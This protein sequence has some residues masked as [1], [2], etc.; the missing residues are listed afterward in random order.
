[1][2]A[3]M[4]IALICSALPAFAA[5]YYVDSSEG[6][7]RSAG[8]SPDTAWRGLDKVNATTFQPGDRILLKAGLVWSGRLWPK[9]SGE[10]GRPIAIDQYGEGPKPV[11]NGEG[12]AFE[13]IHLR[14]QQ[15]WEI[16]N[17]EVTNHGASGAAPRAGVR[18]LGERG[19]VLNHIHLRSLDV[20]G[21]NGDCHRGRDKGKCNA[22]IL[23]DVIGDEVRTRFHDVLIEG[24]RLHGCDRSGIKTWTDWGRQHEGGWEPYTDLVIRGNM[25]DDI[26]GDGIVACMA[27]GPLIEH[28]VVSNCNRRSGDYNVAIWVWE[29]D[30]A[31]MQF[32]EAYLTRTKK[33]GQGF[34]VDGFTRRTIVQYNYSHD[35]EGGFILLCNYWEPDQSFFNDGVIVRYNISQN[36]RERIFQIGGKVTNALICNNTIYVGKGQGDAYIIQDHQPAG[37]PGNFRYWNNIFYNLGSGGYRLNP[38][39][40]SVFD[41]NAFFGTHPDTEPDDPHKI[42]DDPKLVSPGSGR[43]GRDTVDGYRLEPDSPCMDSGVAIPDNGGRDYWGNPVPAGGGTD[44]GAHERPA[45]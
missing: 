5:T 45:E 14:D 7:D 31:V 23:F 29:T 25:L 36:D 43:I 11:I 8:T 27:D 2:V 9:G 19:G 10:E 24:C 37:L 6:E 40:N 28:N 17:L 3:V 4:C 13:A 35:N 30:D 18:V 44:R 39:G 15:H 1:M 20:H 26:G 33:D 16:S 12:A 32:N 21:V 41:Y 34:D 42:T 38:S 22:G